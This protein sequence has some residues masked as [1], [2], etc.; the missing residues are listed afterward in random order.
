[1]KTKIIFFFFL[2]P[3]LIFACEGQASI[4]VPAVV[5][6]GS[7]LVNLSV[8]LIPGTTEVFVSTYPQTGTSTQ[9][10]VED[11][12]IYA[13]SK[14]ELQ[15]CDAIVKID[16]GNFAGFVDGP[17][18]GA[19]LAVLTYSAAVD[20]KVRSDAIITGSVDVFGNV[21]SVGG[22]YEKAMAAAAND[23]DYFIIPEGS[24]LELLLLKNAK[25]GLGIEILEATNADELI[26]FMLYNK[27]LPKASFER[28]SQEMP[29]L[30]VI[31]SSGIADF[32]NVTKQMIDAANKT[33]EK[34]PQA[35]SES[36]AMKKFFRKEMEK[37]GVFVEKGYLFTAANNAFLDYIELSTILA[38]YSKKA[39][40]SDKEESI[41][42]CL[43]SLPAR[44]KTNENYEWLV[45]SDLRHS[46]ALFRLNS[47]DIEA[48]ELLEEKFIVYNDLM[49]ADAW[50]IVS[51][52]LNSN[53]VSSGQ[54]IDESAWKELA[55]QKIKEASAIENMDP[56][57]EEH[58]YSAEISYNQG[59]Y[60]AAI[61]DSVYVISMERADLEMLN[62][63]MDELKNQTDVL[64][65]ENRTSLWGVVYQG[66]GAYLA[67]VNS[68]GSAYAIITYARALDAV[69]QEMGDLAKPVEK[70]MEFGSS[71][72]LG[73]ILIIFLITTLLLFYIAISMSY[74]SHRKAMTKG[75]GI[76]LSRRSDGHTNTKRRGSVSRIKQKQGRTKF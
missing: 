15:D 53:A 50:C 24:Y 27:S 3:I 43:D 48:P 38:I 59:K 22:I 51:D 40:L 65:K 23:V 18:A 42:N 6:D 19:A 64:L 37:Q 39:D 34:L 45:G 11:A 25:Q 29:N 20:E 61:Y 75:H 30:S 35:D 7:S 46:W 56:A 58:I 12:A 28:V 49:Y 8:R 26:D 54:E 36:L 10:S 66:H 70:K 47:T 71:E 41:G 52:S 33:V 62:M 1:M 73:A 44:K 5:G 68:T 16:T 2:I 31:D 67:Q 57:N 14:A 74:K 13:F 17:S 60:G 4:L 32:R 9:I 21:G 76:R 69:T 63:T 55:E 72:T